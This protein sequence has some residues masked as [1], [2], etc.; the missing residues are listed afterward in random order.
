[1]RITLA[2]CFSFGLLISGCGGSS[3]DNDYEPTPAP[4]PAGNP[5]TPVVPVGGDTFAKLQTELFNANCIRCHNASNS[6]NGVILTSYQSI[7]QGKTTGGKTLVVPGNSPES[8][9]FQV[10]DQ[11]IMP[12]TGPISRDLINRLACW[13]DQGA[14]ETE[15]FS[16][17]TGP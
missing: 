3:S 14:P 17:S 15:A 13:I 12:P 6:H 7:V 1:M 8:R 9:V 2:L 11:G 16:C 4:A 5:D 10:L